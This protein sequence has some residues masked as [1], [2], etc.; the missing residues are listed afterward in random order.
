MSTRQTNVIW[1]IIVVILIATIAY[2]AIDK[3]DDSKEDSQQTNQ[4]KALVNEANIS[5]DELDETNKWETYKDEKYNFQLTMMSDTNVSKRNYEEDNDKLTRPIISFERD[6]EKFDVSIWTDWTKGLD[7]FTYLDFPATR[8]GTLDGQPAHIVEAPRGYCDI[9]CTEPFIAY[10][11]NGEFGVINLVFYGDTKLDKTEQYI[12][13]SF[14]FTPRETVVS[15]KTYTNPVYKYSFDYP[16]QYEL[17]AEGTRGQYVVDQA[18]TSV[19]FAADE[20]DRLS[21]S[22]FM[23]KRVKLL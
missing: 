16:S 13:D 19:V 9:S 3:K 23:F 22:D 17:R 15:L 12:L 10:S 8:E 14:K 20:D 2:M 4:N 18:S 21:F 1:S 6:I 7:N 11:A 5:T